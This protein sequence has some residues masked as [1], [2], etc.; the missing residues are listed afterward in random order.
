MADPVTVQTIR[1]R[2]PEFC[3]LDNQDIEK[4]ITAASCYINTEQ[5]GEN[6]AREG[7]IYLTGH[8][9]VF[10]GRGNALP[11]GPIASMGEGGL[12]VG[13]SVS[14]VFT[15]SAFGATAYGRQFLELRRTAMPCRCA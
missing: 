9:L 2:L 8:F 7:L 3:K 13:F 10:T 4:A 15:D 11:S 6:R 1:D 12:S 14:T 5:W